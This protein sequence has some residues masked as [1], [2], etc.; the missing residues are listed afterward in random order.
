MAWNPR[1][2][3]RLVRPYQILMQLDCDTPP[4]LYE[5][6]FHSHHILLFLTY[7][8]CLLSSSF[9]PPNHDHQFRELSLSLVILVASVSP[10]VLPLILSPGPETPSSVIPVLSEPP[11]P[12]TTHFQKAVLCMNS[13]SRV[14]QSSKALIN[15]HSITAIASS[16]AHCLEAVSSLTPCS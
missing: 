15:V 14:G 9:L 10:H 12:A 4:S 11:S 2:P 6:L 1:P 7:S 13:R 5:P 3:S 8:L 16:S